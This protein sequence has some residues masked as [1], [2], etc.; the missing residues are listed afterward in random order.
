MV[1]LDLIPA[2]EVLVPAEFHLLLLYAYNFRLLL[3]FFFPPT[4]MS[5]S[6]TSCTFAM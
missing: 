6:F 2:G 4:T 3:A 1:T 5:S